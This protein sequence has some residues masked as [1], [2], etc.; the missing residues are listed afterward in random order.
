MEQAYGPLLDF[1]ERL[2]QVESGAERDRLQGTLQEAADKDLSILSMR[3]DIS[4]PGKTI[5][6]AFQ[7]ARSSFTEHFCAAPPAAPLSS[8]SRV[9]TSGS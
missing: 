6:I 2:A 8:S 9:F 3:L 5:E 7:Y 4:R 1:A